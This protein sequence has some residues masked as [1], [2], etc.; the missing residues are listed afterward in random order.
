MEHELI[1]DWMNHLKTQGKSPL[2][3]SGYA[4]KVR[5]LEVDYPGRGAL[6]FATRELE[7]HIAQQD[8]SDATR[9]H[10]I[11]A[12]HSFFDFTCQRAGAPSPMAGIKYPHKLKPVRTTRSLTAEE[13]NQ[14]L[15]SFDT[16]RLIGLRDMAMVSL[17]LDTGLRAAEVCRL[18]I[19]DLHLPTRRL[20]VLAKG[21]VVRRA[22]FSAPVGNYLGWWLDA[23]AAWRLVAPRE[24]AV[25]LSLNGSGQGQGLTTDGLRAIFK[26]I[27]RRAGLPALSPHDLRRSFA[28]IAL[29]YG[30]PT[31]LV[32]VAGG[33]L[34]I[35]QLEAYSRDLGLDDF[36]DN[37]APAGRL[38][39]G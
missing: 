5:R 9:K 33:W 39:A 15:A 29:R 32:Q 20:A 38:L 10:T 18:T 31:R 26:A 8:H 19:E 16:S 14:L 7:R 2:T 3:V 34:N 24:R 37:Y 28:T 23:R 36:V 30:A 21:G 27:A 11:A 17:M 4:W 12:Y 22:K 25:F 13:A 35:N 1:A 6:S